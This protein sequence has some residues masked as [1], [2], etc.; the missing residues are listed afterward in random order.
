M[1]I[2]E[3]ILITQLP[4]GFSALSPAAQAVWP[5]SKLLSL[6]DSSAW[7]AYHSAGWESCINDTWGFTW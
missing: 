2:P 7:K 4:T 6:S 3:N 5:R 1:I